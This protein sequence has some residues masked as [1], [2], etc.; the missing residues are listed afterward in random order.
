MSLSASGTTVWRN[1]KARKIK[2]ADVF[3]N[4]M[5]GMFFLNGAVEENAAEKEE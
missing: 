5:E 3:V 2:E 1:G 4:I